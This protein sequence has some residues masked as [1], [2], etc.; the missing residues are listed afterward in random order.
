[1]R[2]KKPEAEQVHTCEY[3]LKPVHERQ[4]GGHLLMPM[5]ISG[6]P[7][8]RVWIHTRCFR[9]FLEAA[10]ERRRPITD[11]TVFT[12]GYRRD[13]PGKPA[14]AGMAGKE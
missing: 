13:L 1:M 10:E 7:T 8:R 9:A 11:A 6:R 14:K 5:E 12:D 3:C 2:T 4:D